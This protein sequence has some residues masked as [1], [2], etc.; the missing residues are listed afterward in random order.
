MSPPVAFMS[1]FLAFAESKNMVEAAESLGIS[2]PA[3]TVHLRKF[4]AFFPQPLF[5]TSGRKKTLT[6]FGLQL[7]SIVKKHLRSLDLDLQDLNAKFQHPDHLHLKIAGRTE[8]LALFAPRI[9]FPGHLEFIGVDGNAAVDGLLDRQFDLAISNHLAKAGPLHGKKIFSDRFSIVLPKSWLPEF[10]EASARL[11]HSLASK[12]YLS[13]KSQDS[14]LHSLLKHW[15]VEENPRMTKTLSH[16]GALIDMVEKGQGWALAPS[17][18]LTHVSKVREIQ[19]SRTILP[20][21]DFF[22]LYRKELT[23]LSWFKELLKEFMA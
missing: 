13:Y 2:Q 22:L 3:L 18:Y 23:S 6:P 5:S 10:S 1:S 11:I 21:V 16:W 12:P 4:E 7:Q 20:E 17:T 9:S 8:L 14:Q 15:R 19:I